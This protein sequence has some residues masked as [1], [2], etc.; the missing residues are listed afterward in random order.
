MDWLLKKAKNTWTSRCRLISTS[1]FY[2]YNHT[3]YCSSQITFWVTCCLFDQGFRPSC[4]SMHLHMEARLQV[5]GSYG[6]Y[7]PST[8]WH[9][10]QE[11]LVSFMLSMQNGMRQQGQHPSR[12]R[13]TVSKARFIYWGLEQLKRH[14]VQRVPGLTRILGLEKTVLRKIYVSGTVG[15]PLLMRKSPTY[16]YRSPK[17]VVVGSALVIAA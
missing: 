12:Q 16:I 1:G 17:T 14:T 10:G 3:G 13:T 15:G 5:S 7:L 4:M 6:V 2:L 11:W 8:V 9:C